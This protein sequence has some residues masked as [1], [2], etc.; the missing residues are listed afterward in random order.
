MKRLTGLLMLTL[1]TIS[2][3][4]GCGGSSAGVTGVQM[5]GSIQ[6]IPLSLNGVVATL[7]GTA[8]AIG[9]TDATGTEARFDWPC[10]ITT[11][12]TNLFVADSDNHTI[13]GID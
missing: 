4:V 11:D 10:S 9:S 5:G 3:L 7:A 1:I 13:R 8:G 12:G 2:V 6:G